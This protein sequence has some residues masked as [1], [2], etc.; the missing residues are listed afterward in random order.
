MQTQDEYAQK[1]PKGNNRSSGTQPHNILQWRPL[2]ATLS[3]NRSNNCNMKPAH[4][5][6]VQSPSVHSDIQVAETDLIQVM[7]QI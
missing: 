2:E 4:S 5:Y 1:S 6:T 7:C 3:Q